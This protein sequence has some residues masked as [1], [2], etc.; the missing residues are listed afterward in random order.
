MR[1]AICG[2]Q[3]RGYWQIFA[4]LAYEITDLR[5]FEDFTVGLSKQRENYRFPTDQEF[6][7]SLKESDLYGMRVCKHLLEGLEN[8]ETKEPSD[9]SLFSIEHI[10]PQNERLSREWRKMLGDEWKDTQKTWLHRLGNLTLTAYNS[11]Y[12]DRSFEEKKSIVGGFGD[13]SVRLNKFV[14]EQTTWDDEQIAKRTDSLA[15]MAVKVWPALHVES[16]LISAADQ[17][18][19]REQAAR[20]DASTLAMSPEARALFDGLRSQVSEFDNNTIEIAEGKS[21]SYHSPTFFLEVLPRRYSLTL[22]LPLDFNQI[23]D[24]HNV[25]Q[26]AT[27]WQF[28]QNAKYEGGVFISLRHEHEI[29]LALPLIRQA[30]A[31][32]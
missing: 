9:T 27:Q 1:R 15:R 14:R 23:D 32:A 18:K 5:P 25:A 17:R 29:Q 28:F 10:M 21:I 4:T 20:Q 30:Y 3:T 19:M 6:L 13:S 8:Y 26:D 7:R 24:P 31:S 22:L 11:K 2:F 16:D 12:S